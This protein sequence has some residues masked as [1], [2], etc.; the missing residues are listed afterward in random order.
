MEAPLIS[1][2]RLDLSIEP[3][4]RTGSGVAD[5]PDFR[6][7][8]SNSSRKKKEKK[9][10]GLVYYHKERNERLARHTKTWQHNIGGRLL[11][12]IWQHAG[13]VSNALLFFFKKKMIIHCKAF[14]KFQKYLVV[15]TCHLVKVTLMALQLPSYFFTLVFVGNF[16]LVIIQNSGLPY[17]SKSAISSKSACL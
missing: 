5:F 9:H 1:R 12:T 17:P 16:S 2:F 7:L 13:L 8:W 6:V 3:W 11:P 10:P 14:L 15:A 4:K